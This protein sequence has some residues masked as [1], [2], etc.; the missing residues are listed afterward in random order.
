MRSTTELAP[1]DCNTFFW[2]SPRNGWF[3]ILCSKR[4]FPVP[5]V[6]FIKTTWGPILNADHRPPT[7]TP[8]AA[9]LRPRL[10]SGKRLPCL[11]PGKRVW[12]KM[13]KPHLSGILCQTC[14]E[15]F[16]QIFMEDMA[17]RQPCGQQTS[18]RKPAKCRTFCGRQ[19]KSKTDQP[20]ATTTLPQK[21]GRFFRS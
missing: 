12:N 6:M 8:Y 3:K 21:L 1:V 7:T 9:Q 14:W 20:W 5:L 10:G 19:E 17:K 2:L 13:E 18:F 15:N 16:K 4:C 11:R